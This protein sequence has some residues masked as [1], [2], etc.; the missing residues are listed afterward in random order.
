MM[1][2]VGNLAYQSTEERVEQAFR[3]F[4][5]VTSVRVGRNPETGRAHG[6]ALV[7]MPDAGEARAAMAGLNQH[8]VDGRLISVCAARPDEEGPR[9]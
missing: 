3:A 7:D 1:L 2:F 5:A 4:G 8:D 9:R 6:F